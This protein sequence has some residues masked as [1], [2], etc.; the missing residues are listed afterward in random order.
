MSVIY[1][2]MIQNKSVTHILAH[3]KRF[4]V[5][6][7]NEDNENFILLDIAFFRNFFFSRRV[8]KV[9]SLFIHIFHVPEFVDF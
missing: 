9:Y 5:P 8:K 4:H 7:Y 3:V 1:I 6:E 2:E